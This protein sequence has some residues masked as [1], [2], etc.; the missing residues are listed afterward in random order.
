MVGGQALRAGRGDHQRAH[1]L[2]VSE[3]DLS[4][5]MPGKSLPEFAADALTRGVRL[6]VVTRGG[7]GAVAWTASASESVSAVVVPVVDTVGAGDTFQAALLTWLAEHDCLSPQACGS[8][9]A[10]QLRAAL[11]FATCAASITCSRRG[12]DLPRRSELERLFAP[13]AADAAST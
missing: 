8:M 11:Q 7:D 5:L 3:E 12:A 10:P 13:G 1:L 9:R 4:L 2:K 6:V